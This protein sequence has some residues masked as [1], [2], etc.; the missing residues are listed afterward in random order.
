MG[1]PVPSGLYRMQAS[2]VVN[3]KT[4]DVSVNTLATVQSVVTNPGD[5]SVSLELEGGKSVLM[6]NVKRVGF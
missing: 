2:A 5:G 3:G 1:T 6:S 4:T